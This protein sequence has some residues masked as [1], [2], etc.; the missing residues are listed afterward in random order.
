MKTNKTVLSFD[1]YSHTIT[2]HAKHKTAI[3]KTQMNT[4]QAK[5]L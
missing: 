1:T 3:Q 5:Q 2:E 4:E